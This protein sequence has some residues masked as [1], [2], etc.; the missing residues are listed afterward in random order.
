VDYFFEHQPDLL[1]HLTARG[2]LYEYVCVTPSF[3]HV[4]STYWKHASST[5][6]L[7]LPLVSVSTFLEGALASPD[8]VCGGFSGGHGALSSLQASE[9]TSQ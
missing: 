2:L 6:P 5:S 9:P 1:G 4:A 3:L 7:D 8:A